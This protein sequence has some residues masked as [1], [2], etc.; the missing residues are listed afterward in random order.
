MPK[1]EAGGM[2]QAQCM[3]ARACVRWGTDGRGFRTPVA[4]RDAV[5]VRARACTMG[6]GRTRVQDTRRV[7]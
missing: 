5:H 1:L 2:M 7:A 6:Q 3:C 4:L